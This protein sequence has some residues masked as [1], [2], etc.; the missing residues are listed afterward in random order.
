MGRRIRK[1]K[2]SGVEWE[3]GVKEIRP[4]VKFE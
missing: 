1:I 2:G 4:R 3:K